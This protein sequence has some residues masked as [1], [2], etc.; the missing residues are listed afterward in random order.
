MSRRTTKSERSQ[1][2]PV[3]PAPE[4]VSSQE[5][6]FLERFSNWW[7]HFDRFGW[8]V[9]GILFIAFTLLTLAGLLGWTRGALLTPWVVLLNRWMGWGRYLVV[10]VLGLL[11]LVALLLAAQGF[12]RVMGVGAEML[13]VSRE[14]ATA[15]ARMAAAVEEMSGKDD[16]EK[17][18]QRRM[19]SY[20]GSQQEK[21]LERQDAMLQQQGELTRLMEELKRN[22]EQRSS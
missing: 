1:K 22:K 3:K 21:L 9:L 16:R 12:Q 6:G 11:G 2:A 19:L 15:Q 10:V 20:L 7:L 4:P 13:T 14:H 8:D 18:E 5:K 17:E